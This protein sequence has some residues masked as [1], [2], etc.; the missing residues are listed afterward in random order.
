MQFVNGVI[1]KLCKLKANSS[2]KPKLIALIE[3]LNGLLNGQ[4]KD[5]LVKI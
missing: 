5:F 2:L 1:D 4:V 3:R